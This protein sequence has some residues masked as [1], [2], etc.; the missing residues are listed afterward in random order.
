MGTA[1]PW[2]DGERWGGDG[3]WCVSA[4]GEEGDVDCMGQVGGCEVEEKQTK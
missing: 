4:I 1:P 2:E 3:R